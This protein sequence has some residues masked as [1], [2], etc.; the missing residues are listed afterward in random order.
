VHQHHPSSNFLLR[1]SGFFP[2]VEQADDQVFVKEVLVICEI[3][4]RPKWNDTSAQLIKG[5]RYRLIAIGTWY[6]AS[7]ACGPEGYKS[8]NLFFRLCE[9]FRRAPRADW[10][11][12]VG[13][14]NRDPSTLF[15]IGRSA[16]IQAIQGGALTCFANDLPFMYGNNS[17]S[18][19]LAVEELQ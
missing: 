5:R 2:T 14:I 18:L 19:Q 9:R 15:T 7:I 13:A 4:A 1:V 17:G 12:L 16:T 3:D 8:F 6:D 11:C 10:F